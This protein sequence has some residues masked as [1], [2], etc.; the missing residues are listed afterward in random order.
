MRP[1]HVTKEVAS[2]LVPDSDPRKICVKSLID[3]L[4]LQEAT[5]D[6]KNQR[7]YEILFFE[8]NFELSKVFRMRWNE[9]CST[10]KHLSL[11]EKKLSFPK[12]F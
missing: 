10:I 6:T 11:L 2:L 7:K 1:T 8:D 12:T 5:K 4:K 9:I 3:V